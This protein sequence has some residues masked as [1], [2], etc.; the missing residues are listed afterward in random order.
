[1]PRS[2]TIGAAA[3]GAFVHADERAVV[4]S[5]GTRAVFFEAARRRW[6]A[7]TLGILLEEGRAT[8]KQ[9]D[10]VFGGFAREDG[11]VTLFVFVGQAVSVTL[12]ISGEDAR[13]LQA[14]LTT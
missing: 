3:A 5:D 2:F 13:A 12:T 10:H 9:S 4:L 6:V 8:R 7:E 11:S 14:D 1:M